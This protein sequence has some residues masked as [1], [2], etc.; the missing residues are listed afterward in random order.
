[1]REFHTAS[2]PTFDDFDREELNAVED[3]LVPQ[4]YL[5]GTTIF[6]EGDT[7]RFMVFISSGR[8][9]I[10]KEDQDENEQQLA[11]I[12]RGATLGEMSL[13]DNSPRSAT[14]RAM[15]D[16]DALLLSESAFVKLGHRSPRA[17]LKLVSSFMRTLS[18]R[19]RM[20]S[21][22]LTDRL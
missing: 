7:G 2:I 14:A 15:V 13:F 21:A 5:K 4:T 18:L 12:R 9:E 17:A 1:V 16:V 20:T 8:V 19:L 6:E 10:T 3:L 11:V 22:N